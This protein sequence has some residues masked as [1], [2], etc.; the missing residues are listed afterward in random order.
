MM[1]THL[2]ICDNY[3]KFQRCQDETCDCNVVPLRTPPGVQ[4]DVPEP[5][6]D[7]K[8]SGHYLGLKATP[9]I[10]RQKGDFNPK[11]QITKFIQSGGVI[12]SEEFDILCERLIVD[13]VV[14]TK[15]ALHIQLI[16]IEKEKRSLSKK[17]TYGSVDW[18]SEEDFTKIPVSLIKI[19]ARSHGL[20]TS[21]KKGELVARI[22]SHRPVCRHTSDIV[23][24]HLEKESN[25]EI[26]KLTETLDGNSSE[27]QME[28]DEED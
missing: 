7:E 17:K 14:A 27:D 10:N 20:P 15:F 28:S 1:D 24:D 21:G 9:V 22:K 26:D 8:N 5:Y 4:F 12:N 16:G 3:M 13:K 18:N 23:E 11:L 25:E 6:P 2:V 19:Y